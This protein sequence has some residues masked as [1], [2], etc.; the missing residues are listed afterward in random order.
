[1]AEGTVDNPIVMTSERPAGS[2]NPG[3]WGGLVVCGETVNNQGA[4]IELE[5]N[6]QAYHGGTVALDDATHSSGVIRY[7]RIEYAGVPIN[8][9]EEVNTLTMGSVGKGTTIEYVQASYGLDDAFE[10]FGGSVDCNYLIAYRGLD[11]DFDVDFGY[12]GHVQFGLGIRDNALADQ[13]GSNGFEVDNN[14]SG[15]A[16]EPFTSGKFSNMTLIGPK[17][18]RETPVN[19]Q[20]QHAAQLRRASK[21]KIYNTF[22]T[23]YPHGLYIDDSRGNTSGYALADDLRVRN[24]IIAGVDGWG[25]NGFGSAYDAAL[26]GTITGLPFLDGAG[27]ARGNHP[28]SEP[29]GLGLRGN[30][31]DGW[32]IVSWF[33]TPAFNNK[34]LAAWNEAGIDGSIFDLVE[35]P[36]LTPSAG[37]LLL[38]YAVWDNVP[39]AA[40][41]EQVPFIGAFGT[42]DWTAGWA[43]F[44]PQQVTYY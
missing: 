14:G 7:V 15:A 28:N 39:E 26:E 43:E 37:S 4:N 3:D 12:S 35:S 5:G 36:K 32:N 41:F 6:Y 16:V 21:L 23:G 18:T 25:G 2:K 19:G 33:N 30:D 13:S 9:N 11:D 31:T 38:T 22:M 29:R 1:M 24:T 40:Q 34:R 8:P 27:N 44:M 42:E 17:K 20:F 10:W